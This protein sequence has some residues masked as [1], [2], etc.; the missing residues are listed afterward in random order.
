MKKFALFIIFLFLSYKAFGE[1]RFYRED[2][3][4][5]LSDSTFTV[6]G[7]YY[8][9][10]TSSDIYHQRLFYPFPQDSLYG[11]VDKVICKN[12]TRLDSTR[13]LKWDQRGAHLLV[14]I[15]AQDSTIVRIGYE[16]RIMGGTAEY[17]LTTTNYWGRGF[18]QANYQLTLP[19]YLSLDSLSY[20]PDKLQ[21]TETTYKLIWQLSNFLPQ[22][23]FIIK[24]SKSNSAIK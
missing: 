6:N 2:L 15:P 20:I 10:N 14:I 5:N 18:Q 13:I 17:I 3:H 9:R 22:K 8:L 24:F 19:K 23:N 16:Q 11:N 7:L 4:F 1:L 12:T 21:E